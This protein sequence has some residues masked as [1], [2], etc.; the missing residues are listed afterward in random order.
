MNLPF[1]DITHL[2]DVWK[3]ITIEEFI[4]RSGKLTDEQQATLNERFPLQDHIYMHNEFVALCEELAE[5]VKAM[6]EIIIRAVLHLSTD[7]MDETI[8]YKFGNRSEILFT[9]F[10]QFDEDSDVLVISTLGDR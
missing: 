9:Q 1:T 3:H 2:G 10:N 4:E 7:P 5:P 8:K 6:A